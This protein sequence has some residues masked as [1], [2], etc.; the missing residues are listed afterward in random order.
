MGDV[1]I[2]RIMTPSSHMLLE[3]SLSNGIGTVSIISIGLME[4]LRQRT[5]K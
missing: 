2:I 5:V 1:M 3:V 4:K